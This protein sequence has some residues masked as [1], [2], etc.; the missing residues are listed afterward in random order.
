M[1][2]DEHADR[3][4]GS[5]TLGGESKHDM[6][7]VVRALWE[8][9]NNSD[10]TTDYHGFERM[11]WLGVTRGSVRYSTLRG[12]ER[13]IYNQTTTGT[14]RYGTLRWLLKMGAEHMW[15]CPECCDVDS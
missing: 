13:R 11:V 9:V 15:E 6:P 12:R 5:A 14:I 2:G 7:D 1:V 4:T 8:Q 10:E 3:L